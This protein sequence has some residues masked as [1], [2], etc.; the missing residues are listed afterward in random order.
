MKTITFNPETHRLVPIE[1]TQEMLDHTS[2]PQS[3]ALARAIYVSMVIAVPQPEPVEHEPENEPAVSAASVAQP[4]PMVSGE[5]LRDAFAQALVGVYVCGRVW[6]AWQ[7]GTMTEDD[8]QP[9]SECDEVLDSLVEAERQ[10][11]PWTPASTPPTESDGE[12]LVRMSD[13]HCEIAWAVYWNHSSSDFAR[14]VF[15]DPDED[16][17]P[18]EWMRIPKGGAA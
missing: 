8:F 6:E 17:T 15:R 3:S 18:V 7:V 5:I 10:F 12:V 1:P 9:A 16:E 14:W 2:A 11:N 13:G 4:A